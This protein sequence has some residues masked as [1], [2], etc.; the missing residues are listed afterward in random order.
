MPTI[1]KSKT[2]RGFKALV[3]GDTNTGKTTAITSL[4]LAGQ[5]VFFLSADPN[6]QSGIEAGRLLYKLPDTAPRINVMVPELPS[7]SIEALIENLEVLSS[8]EYATYLNKPTGSRKQY[9]GF[10]NLLTGMSNFITLEGEDCGKPSEWGTGNTLVIDSLSVICEEIKKVLAGVKPLT[11]PQWQEAQ[12]KLET[13][14]NIINCLTCNVVLLGHATKDKDEINGGYKIYPKNM[15]V[16]LNATFASKFSDVLY[17]QQ[18]NGKF[19]WSTKHSEAVV[20]GRNVPNLVD[21]L[22]QDY[23]QFFI[24]EE[25]A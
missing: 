16:A 12:N 18:L 15:G 4:L 21:Q 19:V 11:V 24:K 1:Y 25:I 20:A 10:S 9:A 7:I 2:L 3:Y 22:P 13:V 5:K 6:A 8:I 17:S 23:R 14:I